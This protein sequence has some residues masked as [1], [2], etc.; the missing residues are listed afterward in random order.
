[1]F[2]CLQWKA[3]QVPMNDTP[4]SFTATTC[5]LYKLVLPLGGGH[6]LLQC[7]KSSGSGT[8]ARE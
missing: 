3:G 1:M 4:A 8:G 7:V 2:G 6:V 5:V